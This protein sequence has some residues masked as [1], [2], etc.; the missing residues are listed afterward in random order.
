[1]VVFTSLPAVEAWPDA[2]QRISILKVF[3][4]HESYHL[5]HELFKTIRK[6]S[7]LFCTGVTD[8]SGFLAK[9]RQPLYL[10][11]GLF[12]RMQTLLF[13]RPEGIVEWCPPTYF[14]EHHKQYMLIDSSVFDQLLDAQQGLD[15]TRWQQYVEL[16]QFFADVTLPMEYG[17]VYTLFTYDELTRPT[18]QL[19]VVEQFSEM[20]SADAYRM[21]NERLGTGHPLLPFIEKP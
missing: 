15:E 6:K 14:N 19:K 8:R 5:T 16:K 12:N 11:M 7:V 20:L 10:G 18:V 9:I 17:A 4:R 3:T 2:Q 13:L 21:I 1:M